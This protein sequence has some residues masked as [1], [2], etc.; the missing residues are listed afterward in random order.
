MQ[1]LNQSQ[2]AI[3]LWVGDVP[4]VGKLHAMKGGDDAAMHTI[5]K[6]ARLVCSA[7]PSRSRTNRWMRSGST[8]TCSAP[9]GTS[10]SSVGSAVAAAA[11]SATCR[12]CEGRAIM[13]G[14]KESI[15]MGAVS[16]W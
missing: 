13:G 15:R 12:D 3:Q 11:V 6:A 4:A 16:R 8:G 10:P 5:V 1:P 7:F 14:G 2:S 9:V